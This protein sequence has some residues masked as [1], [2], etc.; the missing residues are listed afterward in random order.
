MI[1]ISINVVK[2]FDSYVCCGV[3]PW[4]IPLNTMCRLFGEPSPVGLFGGL[5]N[6][7]E[8][9]IWVTTPQYEVLSK[10]ECIYNVLTLINQ[11]IEEYISSE[12]QRPIIPLMVPYASHHVVKQGIMPFVG[13]QYTYN[14]ISYIVIR[15]FIE[16]Y[17]YKHIWTCPFYADRVRLVPVNGY[18]NS[19][20][21]DDMDRYTTFLCVTYEDAVVC[22]TYL[23]QLKFD[24]AL[25]LHDNS[26]YAVL[27]VMC[28]DQVSKTTWNSIY[29]AFAHIHNPQTT[30]A[31]YALSRSLSIDCTRAINE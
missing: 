9:I 13:H 5:I 4:R 23:R 12:Y 10:K 15:S 24:A 11:Y 1:H 21:L 8:F 26:I 2:S 19:V 31:S 6:S 3:I 22:F 14:S 18:D 30:T 16:A 7:M 25:V 20:L 28:C 29:L 17:Y 27:T